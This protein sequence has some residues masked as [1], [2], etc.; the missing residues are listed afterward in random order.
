[1][2]PWTAACQASLSITNSQSPLRLMSIMSLMPSNHLIFCHPRQHQSSTQTIAAVLSPLYSIRIICVCVCV[3]M[4]V[5]LRIECFMSKKIDV[6]GTSGECSFLIS[7]VKRNH[8]SLGR[9]GER[10]SERLYHGQTLTQ[11]SRLGT[12][13]CSQSLL[14][15]T[16]SSGLGRAR[17]WSR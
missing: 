11:H 7:H 4:C 5:C 3:C 12:Q 1:M 14:Q 13:L 9:A 6:A 8:S 16:H 10:G 2:T 17:A 15:H